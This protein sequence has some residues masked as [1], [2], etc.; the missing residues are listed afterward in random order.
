[1]KNNI[2]CIYQILEVLEEN[3][4]G[5]NYDLKECPD[6]IGISQPR[7]ERLLWVMQEQNLIE[8]L[9]KRKTVSGDVELVG[10]PEIT[11]EG[12]MFLMENGIRFGNKGV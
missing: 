11:Y 1:M 2:K 7:Y 4:D 8:G 6:E 12:L 9:E 5:Y 3:M 10:N